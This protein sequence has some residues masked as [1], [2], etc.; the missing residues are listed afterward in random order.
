MP[1][2]AGVNDDIVLAGAHVVAADGVLGPGWIRVA[3]GRIADLGPGSPPAAWAVGDVTDLT[4]RWVFPGFVDIHV[5]GG[6]GASFTE[7]GAEQARQAA[8]FHRAHGST[9]IVASLVTAPLDEM[10][11]RTAMLADLVDEGVIDGIH[12]EGPFLSHARCGAQDPRYLIDPDV[13]AFGRL[14]AAGRGHV[15]QITIA[16]E[17]PGA[18][19]LIRAAVEAGVVASAGHSDA[20][21]QA[22][23][24]AIDAGVTHA[25]HLFNG[26]RPLDHREPGPP[27]AL[28]DRQVTCEVIADGTH[29]HDMTIRLAWRAAGPGNLVLITDAMGAAGMP[30]GRYRL[31]S[32]EVVV[33]GGVARLAEGLPGAGSIAGSTA[34]MAHC[35]RRALRN[36]QLPP[37]DV[38]A[39]ASST[40]AR[41]V[42]LDGETGE[43]R[44]GLAADLV[45]LDTN[46]RLTAVMARGQWVAGV[47]V[48]R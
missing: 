16:P 19:G 8:A 33:S 41:V 5:H 40:P 7:G 13:A 29:L 27:G 34:T 37:P 9:R 46:L 11:Q 4:D 45:V 6:G 42:G 39:A 47:R 36:V 26:S 31:G 1:D 38:A 2:N 15:R 35:V 22:T 30:D 44:P 25:T 10:A 43:L 23:A 17:L 32:Q 28:L 14:V 20:T 3:G 24:A 18:A 21:A 12:L 48:P